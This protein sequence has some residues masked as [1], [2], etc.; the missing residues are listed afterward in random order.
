VLAFIREVLDTRQRR[1]CSQDG[2]RGPRPPPNRS[3]RSAH[4]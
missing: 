4:L 3:S 2:R 1:K